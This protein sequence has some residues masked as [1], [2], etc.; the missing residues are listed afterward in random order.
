MH[1]LDPFCLK[2][3]KETWFR[4]VELDISKV[5]RTTFDTHIASKLEDH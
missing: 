3:R 1:V 4:S 2:I 5:E